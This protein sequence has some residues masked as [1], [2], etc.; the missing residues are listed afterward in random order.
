LIQKP[1]KGLKILK[2]KRWGEEGE[3]KSGRVGEWEKLIG[4]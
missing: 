4:G 3:K 1:V 2:N